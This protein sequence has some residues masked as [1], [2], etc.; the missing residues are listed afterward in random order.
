MYP[1][2]IKILLLEDNHDDVD[3]LI[4]L[5]SGIIPKQNLVAVSVQSALKNSTRI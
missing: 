4:E 3:L 5:L 2:Q 1:V